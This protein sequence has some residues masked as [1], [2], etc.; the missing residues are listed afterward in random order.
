MFL[1]YRSII[2][3]LF[4]SCQSTKYGL[5]YHALSLDI[6]NLQ[7]WLA[8]VAAPELD[9]VGFRVDDDALSLAIAE[10]AA[11]V[12]D[13]AFNISCI[14]CTGSRIPELS[15][16]FSGLKDNDDVT[17]F[18]NGVFDYLKDLATGDFMQI[19]A[20][21]A[22]N[23]AKYQCPHNELYDANYVRKDYGTA[24]AASQDGSTISFLLGLIIVLASL[25][26]GTITIVLITRSIVRRRHAKWVATLPPS[27]IRTLNRQQALQKETNQSLDAST[28]SMFRSGAIPLLMRWSIPIIIIG[29]IGLFLSGHLSL[30]ANVS[31]SAS[32]AGQSFKD[33]DLFEFSVAN[34][35][36]ELWQGECIVYRGYC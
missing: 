16:L 23:D 29:N 31:I 22:V 34:S 9:E 21:R 5:L 15:E 25:L 6:F 8:T 33:E 26:V 3:Y 4:Q 17:A 1:L 11:S 13:L 27:H 12:S 14:K 20:D 35:T 19:A 10:L 28:V 7:C 36:I 2:V 30:A 32:L 18:A 24:L